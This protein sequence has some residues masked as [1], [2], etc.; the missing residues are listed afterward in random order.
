MIDQ[1]YLAILALIYPVLVSLCIITAGIFIGDAIERSDP[2]RLIGAATF[3]TF[4]ARFAILSIVLPGNSGID[5]YA[6][7]EI[8]VLLDACGAGFGLAYLVV[9]VR[10][11]HRRHRTSQRRATQEANA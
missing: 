4:A 8:A 6:A 7:Q 2:A 9:I 5:R 11:R 3:I 1:M 10:R